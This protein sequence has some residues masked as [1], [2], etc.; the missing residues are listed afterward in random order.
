MVTTELDCEPMQVDQ[1][2]WQLDDDEAAS[3]ILTSSSGCTY[4]V[5]FPAGYSNGLPYIATSGGA[6]WSTLSS[7]AI[8]NHGTN[9]P[10]AAI[11]SGNLVN[12]SDCSDTAELLFSMNTPLLQTTVRSNYIYS[13]NQDWQ[14][15]GS[16]CNHRYYQGEALVTADLSQES[17]LLSFDEAEYTAS[18][19]PVESSFFDTASFQEL[20]L[21]RNWSYHFVNPS[22]TSPV[23]GGP[24]ALLAAF[25][26]NSMVAMM[27]DPQL[28]ARA[29][30]LKQRFL[31][32]VMQDALSS[33]APTENTDIDGIISTTSRRI[34]VISVAALTLGVTLGLQLLLLFVVFFASRLS[35][36]PF[37]LLSDPASAISATALVTRNGDD[38]RA[39]LEHLDSESSEKSASFA[40]QSRYKLEDG[41]LQLLK[42][43]NRHALDSE[44]S[45][46][47]DGPD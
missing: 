4:G 23:S 1:K 34:V 36:R 16:L 39:T 35:R 44:S 8:G 17:T 19:I 5:E 25:Y 13:A 32:E 41:S 29:A 9:T 46:G 42:G 24:A 33:M 14:I 2:R 20:F 11:Y 10:T 27:D 28:A 18:R 26:N 40:G 22:S 12:S 38:V 45:K 47:T 30:Q 3:V 15:R 31:G 6:S 43:Q 37:G 7:F 21:T